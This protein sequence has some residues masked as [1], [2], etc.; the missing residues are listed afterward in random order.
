MGKEE[1]NKL[2]AQAIHDLTSMI[3]DEQVDAGRE[4]TIPDSL[5]ED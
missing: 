3:N 2:D 1:D 4:S 5:P